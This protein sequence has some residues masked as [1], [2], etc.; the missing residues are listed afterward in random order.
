M[1]GNVIRE[2]LFMIGVLTMKLE[3]LKVNFSM[4]LEMKQFIEIA[5]QK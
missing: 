1:E 4:I 3:M 5:I 2:K